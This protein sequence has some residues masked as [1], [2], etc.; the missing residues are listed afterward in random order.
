M[1]KCTNIQ[2]QQKKYEV[3]SLGVSKC[4]SQKAVILPKLIST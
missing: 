1:S 4:I 2:L 3:K